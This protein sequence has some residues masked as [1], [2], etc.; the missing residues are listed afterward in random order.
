M[1]LTTALLL[2]GFVQA[3]FLGLVLLW[4][5]RGPARANRLMGLLLLCFAAGIAVPL[6]FEL[7]QWTGTPHLVLLLSI[8]TFLMGPLLLWYVRQLTESSFELGRWWWVHLLPALAN[9]FLIAPSLTL[10]PAALTQSL[11]NPNVPLAFARLIPILKIVSII[12]YSCVCLIVLRHHRQR[13]VDVVADIEHRNLE[14]LTLLILAAFFSV[15][16]LVL[17][18]LLARPLGIP[19]NALDSLFAGGLTVAV[20]LTG[21]MSLRQPEIF[22]GSLASDLA[23]RPVQRSLSLSKNQLDGYRQILRQAE[24]TGQFYLDRDITVQSLARQINIPAHHL[25]HLLNAEMGCNFFAY[26]NALRIQEIKR[27]LSD[28][29][30][31]SETILDLALNAGFN[32]KAT[33]N[34]AFKQ[35][36]GTT[37]S[38]YRRETTKR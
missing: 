33:F 22:S 8:S 3:V 27:Q 10:D 7:D 14:W 11:V 35:I 34:K 6:L 21:W 1:S 12:G 37:P 20:F 13:L 31:A 17:M 32:N 38:Q 19:I 18:W 24:Q 36:A 26:I 23:D 2:A 28:E 15:A 5:R 9:F 4:H 29:R 25:S 16:L 30:F